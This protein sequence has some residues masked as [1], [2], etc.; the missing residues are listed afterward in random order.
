MKTSIL[1]I[2]LLY[3]SSLINIH[4]QVG[5]GTTTPNAALDIESA[6][7]GILIP[8]LT[9]VQAENISTPALGELVFATTN[10]GTVINNTGFWYYDG[11]TWKPFGATMQ[12][13]IDI[14][15]G[16]GTLTS[17]RTVNMNGNNLAFD[18]NKLTIDAT[19]QRI[20][21]GESSPQHTLDINGNARVRNLTG[22]NVVAL[23]DGTLAIGPK[24][25]YGTVKESLRSTDHNG[26][27]KLDGRAISTLPAVAQANAAT[28]G[29]TGSL[30]NS[31]DRL[32]RQGSSLTT[33]G[34]ST[35]T[36]A[37][38]NFPNYNMTGTTNATGAHTH[39]V[40]S[41]GYNVVPVATGN[42][43]VVRAGRGTVSGTAAVT[44]ATSGAH[45]HSGTVSSGGSGTPFS[46][47]PESITY[48]YFIYLGQ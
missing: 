21:I 39:A 14:Y 23:S 3:F 1:I 17:N 10:D 4:A 36:L 28:L 19:T 9:A 44:L 25:P 12:Q 30:V 41:S 29:I 8:R 38:A 32:M 16:D 15:D 6:R 24:V 18:T 26:W 13:N 27:Y 47:I 31:N 42:A 22:G 35:I 2:P 33:G 11:A 40:T 48:T 37:R 43:Y 7:Q 46:I 5:I 34:T 20:G 45:A